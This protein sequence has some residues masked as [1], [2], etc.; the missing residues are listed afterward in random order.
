MEKNSNWSTSGDIGKQDENTI[1]P[2]RDE[3]SFFTFQYLEKYGH[4]ICTE[5]KVHFKKKRKDEQKEIHGP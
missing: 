5:I 3:H 4:H 2:I 1:Q